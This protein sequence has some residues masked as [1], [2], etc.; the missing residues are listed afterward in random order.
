MQ[1]KVQ[2]SV[3]VDHNILSLIS[4]RVTLIIMNLNE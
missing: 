3:Q 4:T 1:Q 2:Q